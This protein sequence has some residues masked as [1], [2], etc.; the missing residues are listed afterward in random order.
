MKKNKSK[1]SKLEKEFEKKLEDHIK[2]DHK[3]INDINKTKIKK[4]NPQVVDKL[5][6]QL[7]KD[8]EKAQKEEQKRLLKEIKNYQK[9]LE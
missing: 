3:F 4:D 2:P 5:T 1:I 7:N 6:R 8:V 9:N